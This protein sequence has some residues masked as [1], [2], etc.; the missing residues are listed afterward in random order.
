[1]LPF[2]TTSLLLLVMTSL[3]WMH[4]CTPETEGD[5]D[6]TPF[7]EDFQVEAWSVPSPPQAQEEAELWYTIEDQDG[8]PIPDLQQSHTR[9]VHVFVI[10]EDLHTFHHRHHEDFHPLTA[11]DL[12]TATYHF[13]ETFPTSGNHLLAYDFAY[14]NQYHLKTGWVE[15]GGDLPQQAR[16]DT[17]YSESTDGGVTGALTWTTPPLPGYPSSF[18]VHLTDDL[19]EEITDIVQ[20]LG[21]DAHCALV[22]DDLSFVSHT[23]AYVEGMESMP[24]SHTMPHEYPGPELPFR[25]TFPA[26]GTYKIWV[27]FAREADPEVP[28][29]LPFV[30]EVLP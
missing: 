23:H 14:A 8:N 6:T 11:T 29:T 4:G 3:L 28:F 25:F 19:G 9:M 30:F 10:S 18:S 2:P 7:P 16:D 12:E 22:R 27:Q 15:V 17:P 1:M 21:A 13:P 5:D 20:F 24:P 26:A